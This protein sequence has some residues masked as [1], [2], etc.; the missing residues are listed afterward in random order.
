MLHFNVK[1]N[2]HPEQLDSG[3][4][5]NSMLKYLFLNISNMSRSIRNS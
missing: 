2:Y 1:Y 3:G 4:K 5:F